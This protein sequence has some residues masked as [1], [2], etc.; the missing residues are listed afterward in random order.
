MRNGAVAP[1]LPVDDNFCY[2]LFSESGGPKAVRKVQKDARG[3][4]HLEK[5]FFFMETE[6]WNLFQERHIEFLPY[7]SCS[8][9]ILSQ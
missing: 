6:K 2:F 9:E 1:G 3:C 5:S 8:R 4:F 7:A